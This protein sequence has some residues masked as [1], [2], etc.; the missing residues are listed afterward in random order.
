MGDK[1]DVQ[2]WLKTIDVWDEKYDFVMH[3]DHWLT[4]E[5]SDKCEKC[6]AK[7]PRRPPASTATNFNSPVQH[8]LPETIIPITPIQ[9]TT[10][11][12]KAFVT[13]YSSNKFAQ[14]TFTRS[15]R[16]STKKLLNQTSNQDLITLNE[17]FDLYKSAYAE[18]PGVANETQHNLQPT[19]SENEQLLDFA[20][21]SR[22][23]NNT[24]TRSV[25]KTANIIAST[26]TTTGANHGITMPRPRTNFEL[27]TSVNQSNGNNHD[28]IP[29]SMQDVDIH[30]FAQPVTSKIPRI[31]V[32][33]SRVHDF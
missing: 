16:Q 7:G 13:P 22:P 30:E 29:S 9:S 1:F 3:D 32:R 33:S 25:S 14:D 26:P 5:W 4:S 23:Y 11:S 18:T 15:T 2:A 28:F 27:L 31:P 24:I 19:I 6:L 8:D 20:T 17:T 21:P 10:I 12:N